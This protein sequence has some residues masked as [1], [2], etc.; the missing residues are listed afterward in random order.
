MHQQSCEATVLRAEQSE[1]AM[2]LRMACLHAARGALRAAVGVLAVADA[3]LISKAEEITAQLPAVERCADVPALAQAVDSP[4]P[5][6]AGAV[7][8]ARAELVWPS[9]SN[10]W[11]R[12]TP[13][14]RPLDTPSDWSCRCGASTS[15]EKSSCGAPSTCRSQPGERSTP[16]WPGYGARWP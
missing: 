15:K 10:R 6:E 1:E 13:S 11:E 4:R 14:P 3:E 2:D 16:S 8:A 7:E 12:T 5:Q 9:G